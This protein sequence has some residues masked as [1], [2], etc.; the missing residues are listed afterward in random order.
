M[1]GASQPGGAGAE[2]AADPWERVL[3][4]IL[5]LGVGAY[6][7]VQYQPF[8]LPNNDWY[9]F[10]RSARA[11]A[12]GELPGSTKRMPLFPLLVGVVSAGFDARHPELHAA[13]VWNQLFS[14]AGLVGLFGV[15][16]VFLPRGA[17]LLPLLVAGSNQFHYNALQPLVDPSLACFVILGFWAFLMRSDWQYVAAF[18][19][20]LSRYEAAFLIPV[21]FLANLWRE[22]RLVR[23]LVASILAGSGVVAWAAIGAL[24]NAGGSSSYLELMRGMGFQ[25]APGFVLRS[26]KEPFAGWYSTSG[27]GPLV[28]A[29]AIG[30]PVALGVFAG[31]KRRGS[32]AVALLGFG[33]LQV[34]IIVLFGINK[35]RYVLPT[36][37]IWLLFFT[38]GAFALRDA[39]VARLQAP[40]QGAV[41]AALATAAGT[42]LALFW[43]ARFAAAPGIGLPS[44]VEPAYAIALLAAIAIGAR[45]GIG[46]AAARWAGTIG[47]VALCVPMVLGG[48]LAK[49]RSIAKVYWSN[50]ASVALADWFDEHLA[51]S[52]RVVLL[53]R[54]QLLH[55]RD[56]P[57]CQLAVFSDFDAEDPAA[58]ASA[59]EEAGVTL[60]VFTDRGRVSNPSQEHYYRIKR[61]ALAEWFRSGEP[62][63]GFEHLATLPLPAEAQRDPVQIYRREGA[64][65]AGPGCMDGLARSPA[66][67]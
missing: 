44:G 30:I 49:Q 33:L 20:A 61:V 36:Q 19:A 54:S 10:E 51:P 16:R 62:V 47:I 12:D 2:A 48:G 59:L 11:L 18:A 24:G 67:R 42:V 60:A 58:L 65:R 55:L 8:H 29:V 22:R 25:P 9:S 14:L 28:G 41:L 15:A 4:A 31:W 63:P 57:R 1:R 53:P 32:D 35:A 5:L 46:D 37:W 45:V 23:P 43:W 21:L 52:D 64:I 38:I 50:H 56:I 34:A 39:I 27:V 13:L 40:W 66:S 6:W 3:L 7:S 17:I 26:I